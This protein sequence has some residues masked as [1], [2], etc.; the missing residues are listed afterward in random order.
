LGD[1]L[2]DGYGSAKYP[3]ITH[4]LSIFIYR[5]G[6]KR[7]KK[8]DKERRKD[9]ERRTKKD[10]EGQRRTKKDKEGQRRTKKDKEG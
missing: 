3:I 9:K 6:Q 5:E 10:K 4:F 7:I 1:G 8:E 2:H